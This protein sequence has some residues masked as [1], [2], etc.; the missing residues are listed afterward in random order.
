VLGLACAWAPA[1]AA[2][3]SSP[4]AQQCTG[5]I[6]PVLVT[7]NLVVPASCQLVG[8]KVLGSVTVAPGASLTTSAN[9][10]VHGSIACGADSTCSLSST[11]VVGDL[12]CSGT[13]CAV[14]AGK[15]ARDIAV[16]AGMLT[17]DGT[18][19]IGDDLTCGGTSCTV[20]GTSSGTALV[21]PTIGDDVVCRT[22]VC[23]LNDTYVADDVL[24][25]EGPG[26]L[27]VNGSHLDDLG[28]DGV[29]CN[30]DT[31]IGNDLVP[32][33]V[34]RDVRSSNGAYF[35]ARLTT[36]GRDVKCSRCATIDLF[37]SSVGGNV[38]SNAQTSGGLFCNNTISGSLSFAF[39]RQYFITCGGNV[40]GGSLQLLQNSG[41]LAVVGNTIGKDLQLIQNHADQIILA[42]T[43]AG[44]AIQC[45]G[46]RPQPVGGLNTAPKVDRECGP[47]TGPLPDGV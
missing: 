46:N 14:T 2:H 17:V 33:V 30:V 32:T 7:G 4:P 9:A 40:I 27:Y 39:N 6:G 25:L 11:L 26:E 23:T 19:A 28:C 29:R 34:E 45:Q 31:E 12:V 5:P 47:I 41:T 21:G 36:I 15:V 16:T 24:L 35:S 42:N 22:G 20:T 44:H 38:D 1:A 3:G 10:A 37:D 18:A 8:T 43:H 13:S